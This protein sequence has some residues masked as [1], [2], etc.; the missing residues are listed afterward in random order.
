MI[1]WPQGLEVF[2]G[3]GG[4]DVD[5]RSAPQLAYETFGDAYKIIR[6]YTRKPTSEGALRLY[7]LSRLSKYLA[8]YVVEEL[9]DSKLLATWARQFGWHEKNVRKVFYTLPRKPTANET[10]N[11]QKGTIL[12]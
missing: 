6:D 10:L 8:T 4:N 3:T 5:V 11:D 2:D 9:D 12:S 7:Q 1:K